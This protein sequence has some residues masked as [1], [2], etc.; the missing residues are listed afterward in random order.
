MHAQAIAA[1]AAKTLDLIEKKRSRLTSAAAAPALP[2][3]PGI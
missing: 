3:L 2:Q 1:A